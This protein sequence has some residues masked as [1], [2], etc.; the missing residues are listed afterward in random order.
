MASDS[1]STTQFVSKGFNNERRSSLDMSSPAP[2]LR[3][4]QSSSTYASSTENI[5]R[6]LEGWMRSSP[7]NN[8]NTTHINEPHED[9]TVNDKSSN[10]G[11]S[12]SVTTST[13]L[14]CYQPKAEQE[15][16]GGG[17]GGGGGDIVSHEDFDSILSFENMN[18]AAS[19]WDKSTCDSMPAETNKTSQTDAN[20]DKVIHVM[21][22]RN[23]QRSE[24][25][26]PLSIFEKWLFDESAAGQVEEMMEL[27][28]MF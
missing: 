20:D 23:R 11:N 15:G 6:L 5:S 18:N 12:A 8:N 13:T 19:A 28:P 21:T 10:F 14:Q 26:P 25:S 27:S 4:N 7:K 3:V 1:A 9:D 24:N 16:G 17:G 22:E 2:S